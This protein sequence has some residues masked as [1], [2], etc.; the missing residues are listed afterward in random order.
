MYAWNYVEIS[1]Y[2]VV[3]FLALLG[4]TTQTKHEVEGRLLLD[5][6]VRESAAVLELLAREDQ[7]LLVWG[8]A[9]GSIVSDHVRGR[10]CSVYSPLLVLDLGLDIVD[11]VRGLNLEGDGLAREGLDENLHRELH[12]Y[13]HNIR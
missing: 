9:E 6:V 10:L 3:L 2:G 7:A 13:E 4:T 12:F 8:D 1:T 11:G 5:V